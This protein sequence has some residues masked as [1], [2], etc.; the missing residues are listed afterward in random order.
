LSGHVLLQTLARALEWQLPNTSSLVYSP[1]AHHIPLEKKDMKEILPR[2]QTRSGEA[3][4]GLQHLIGAIHISQYTGIHEFKIEARP[5]SIPKNI[6][7]QFYIDVFSFRDPNHIE[8]GKFFFRNLRKIDLV[9]APSSSDGRNGPVGARAL[10]CLANMAALLSEAQNLEDLSF[11]FSHWHSDSHS[12]HGL[13][14]PHTQPIFPY[15]GL[16]ATRPKLRA[17]ALGGIYVD[18]KDIKELISRHRE[19]LISMRFSYCGL[20]AGQWSNIVDDVVFGTK[21]LLFDLDHV[22]EVQI[23]DTTFAALSATEAA[24]WGYQGRVVVSNDGERSFEEPL[25]KSVYAWRNP[26]QDMDA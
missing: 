12:M 21:I 22:N 5:V 14:A 10:E 9:L 17:L 16:K 15:L 24:R 2:S 26:D 4:D 7:A 20:F 13:I 3:H 25:G 1:E 18:E 11:R 23:G 8:A 19:T 6:G